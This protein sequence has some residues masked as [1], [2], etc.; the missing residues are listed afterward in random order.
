MSNRFTEKAEKAL[1]SA[2]TIAEELGHTYIGSEHILLSLAKDNNSAASIVLLKNG[3]NFEKILKTVKE[4]SGYGSKSILTPKDMTP[5]CKKIVENSYRL[6]LK[7]GASKIGT[8]HILLSILDE[9]ECIA[10]KIL[11]FA[12]LDIATVSDDVLTVIK[13]AEK[14]FESHKNKKESN[15]ASTLSQYGKNL[16]EAAR[17]GN[18]DPVIGRE[19][20][21]ERLIRILCRKNK[22]NPCLIGEAGVGKTAIVEGLAMRI[23]SGNVPSQIKGK[24]IISVDLTSM[25]AGAKYRGDFEERIKN[26]L[27]ESEKNKSVILFIDEIHTIVGAG[28]AEGAIDAANIL[29]PKLSRAEIQIIGATTFSEYHKYIEKDAALERRFQAL[30]VNE[31]THSQTVDILKGLKSK[32]EE[33]HSIKISDAAIDAAVT[34]SERYIQ[35]RFFPDKAIDIIDE[36]CAKRNVKYSE[37]NDI[38]NNYKE[39]IK[40][41]EDNKI[42]AIKNQD[43]ALAMKLR[44]MEIEFNSEMFG[45]KLDSKQKN[46]VVTV[47]D[48]EEIINE[49]TGIPIAG[50]YE[51]VNKEKLIHKFKQKI[52][53]QDDAVEA[54]ASAVMRSETGITNP[55]RPK[56]VFLFIGSSGV[57]KTELAKILS[58]ELFFTKKAL[59]RYDMSEFSEKNSVTMLIGSPPGYVGYEEGGALTEKIRRRPYSVLLFDEI[60]KAH[61]DVLNLFLQIMDDGVLR[62]SCGRTVSFKN[63]YIIMT[64]NALGNSYAD[65]NVGFL[66]NVDG[67]KLNEKLYDFFS[68]EFVNR[69]DS[70]IRFKDLDYNSFVSVADKKLLELSARLSALDIEY[71]YNSEVCEYVAKKAA[72]EKLGARV[73]SRIITS[74]FENKISSYMLNGKIKEVISFIKDDILEM[75]VVYSTDSEDSEI[76]I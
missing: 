3:I 38:V 74:E 39:K 20:E 43:Y 4:Y 51:H 37:D 45:L 48:I 33:H 5:R 2:V 16:T 17:C 44:D 76:L 1:N 26:L 65:K 66:N 19:R 70:V 32:Y 62:D 10:T 42:D 47:R 6:S 54:L 52:F 27:N 40:Q 31:P 71:K 68:P 55:D 21:T 67:P 60:E 63:A 18:L 53:G 69:I 25:V 46:D 50:M 56:G 11:V 49:M 29:K 13:T 7:Y 12:G 72:N 9:K 23:A 61:K 73:V 24:N 28:S 59:I 8:E 36:A 41:I 35:D 57:G 15:E 58:E 75:K 14:H 22:N 34:L 30:T 64:S